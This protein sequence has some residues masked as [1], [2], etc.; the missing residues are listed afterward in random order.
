[1][2]EEFLCTAGFHQSHHLPLTREMSPLNQ[3]KSLKTIVLA[4]AFEVVDEFPV[5]IKLTIDIGDGPDN[6][7]KLHC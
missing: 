5:H 7:V 3:F 6:E 1:M 2:T 4:T